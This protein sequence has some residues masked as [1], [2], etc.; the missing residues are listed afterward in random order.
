MRLTFR[1]VELSARVASSILIDIVQISADIQAENQWKYKSRKRSKSV[2]DNWTNTE[3]NWMTHP[4]VSKAP[5]AVNETGNNTQL[6][7][8]PA[9]SDRCDFDV[10][11]L[12]MW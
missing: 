7:R 9:K 1:L 8:T 10:A 4:L 3:M 11:D 5:K 6:P 12:D 2:D